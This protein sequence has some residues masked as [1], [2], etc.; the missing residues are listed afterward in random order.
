MFDYYEHNCSITE[1]PKLTMVRLIFDISQNLTK[2][3]FFESLGSFIT[4][5]FDVNRRNASSEPYNL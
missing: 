5:E 2:I 4:S 3:Y 1:V